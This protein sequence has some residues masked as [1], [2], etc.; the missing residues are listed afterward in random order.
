M[1]RLGSTGCDRSIA[2][3]TRVFAQSSADQLVWYKDGLAPR[4]NEWQCWMGPQCHHR[5]V[6]AQ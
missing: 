4:S 5:T 6:V 2:F 3:D 1:Y